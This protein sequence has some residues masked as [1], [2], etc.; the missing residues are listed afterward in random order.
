MKPRNFTGMSVDELIVLYAEL[1]G[2]QGRVLDGC[3]PSRMVNRLVLQTFA[4][5]DELARRAKDGE[6][7]LARLFAHPDPWVRYNAASAAL[8]VLGA[9]ARKVIQAI[10]DS[11][12]F[13]VAGHAGMTLSLF[14]GAL[15]DLRVKRSD[16][17]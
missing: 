15:S 7:V 8:D 3:G 2:E 16:R 4:I 5:R 13:P 17:P 9:E 14:D 1:S 10:A 12:E 6:K 11:K